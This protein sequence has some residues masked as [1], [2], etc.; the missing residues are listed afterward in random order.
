MTSRETLAK[1]IFRMGNEV[2]PDM[3]AVLDTYYSL[4][5]Q[6]LETYQLQVRNSSSVLVNFYVPV[7]RK[8]LQSSHTS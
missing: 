6:R 1:E 3:S 8:F 7:F 2:F 5:S 4:N